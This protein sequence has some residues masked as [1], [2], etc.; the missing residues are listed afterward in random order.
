MADTPSDA[1]VR[2]LVLERDREPVMFEHAR[3]PG[4]SLHGSG[5]RFTSAIAAQLALGVELARAAEEAG[6]WPGELL[7]RRPS[8][9]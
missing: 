2:D 9:G 6:R 7:A 5:C 3:I 8:R 1:L 4:A